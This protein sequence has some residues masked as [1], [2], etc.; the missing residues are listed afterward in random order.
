MEPP[1]KKRKKNDENVLVL[2]QNLQLKVL[3]LEKKMEQ[4]R[5]KKDYSVSYIS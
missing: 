4:L 3:E 5:E 1:A 2:V